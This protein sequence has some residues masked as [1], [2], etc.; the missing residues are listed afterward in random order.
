MIPGQQKFNA[1]AA[2]ADVTKHVF[3]V[4]QMPVY[5]HSNYQNPF[6]SPKY[7]QDY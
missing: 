2:N 4:P 3:Y 7:I 1:W 6:I 5:P